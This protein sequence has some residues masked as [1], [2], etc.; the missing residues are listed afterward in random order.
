MTSDAPIVF[1]H[2]ETLHYLMNKNVLGSTITPTLSL[3]M[4]KIGFAQ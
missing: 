2:F 4:E 3:H 1:A